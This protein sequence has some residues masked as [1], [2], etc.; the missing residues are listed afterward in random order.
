MTAIPISPRHV[1][2]TSWLSRWRTGTSGSVP[3]RVSGVEAP[4]YRWPTGA[5]VSVLYPLTGLQD[6]GYRV[7]RTLWLSLSVDNGSW[8]ACEEKTA[9]FGV[10][11]S[12]EEALEDFEQALLSWIESLT[13]NRDR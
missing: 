12:Q 10:G 13:G 3:Y 9:I 2:G 5:S 1:S 4:S 6:P 8:M 7:K 11:R